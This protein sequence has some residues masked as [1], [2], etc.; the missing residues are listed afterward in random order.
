MV[1]VDSDGDDGAVVVAHGPGPDAKRVVHTGLQTAQ[2][3]SSGRP[4]WGRLWL[5]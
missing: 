4:G 3:G 1:G 5:A 2:L